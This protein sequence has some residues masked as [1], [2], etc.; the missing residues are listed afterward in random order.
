MPKFNLEFFKPLILNFAYIHS[1]RRK[2]GMFKILFRKCQICLPKQSKFA[3]NS[4]DFFLFNFWLRD[5][6][7]DHN[8]TLRHKKTSRFTFQ[9]KILLLHV[10]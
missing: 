8:E 10:S 5:M 3:T 4:P 9:G 6:S 1:K 7:R 2:L